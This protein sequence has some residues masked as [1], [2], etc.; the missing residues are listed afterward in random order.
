[1]KRLSLLALLAV[2]VGVTGLVSAPASKLEPAPKPP[3]ITPPTTEALDSAIRHGIAFLLKDQNKDGSWGTAERTKGL[4]IYAPVPGAHHAFRTAVTA[5]VLSALIEIG[6]GDDVHKAIDRGEQWLFDNLPILRRA[7]PDALYNIWGHGYAVG[8]LVRMHGRK[9]ADAE[10]R[11]KIEALIQSQ[12]DYLTR[13]ESV[14]GGWG[15]YDFRVGSKKPATD[16]TSFMTAAL[17]VCFK[18]AKDIGQPPPQKVLQAAIDSIHRQQKPDFTYLYGEYM[19]WRPMHPINLPGGSLGR[20]QACNVA[21]RLWGDDKITDEVLKNWL[22][23]LFARNGWLDMGRK[24]PIPHESHFAVAGYFY[25]F[26]HYYAALCIEQLKPDQRAFFQDYLAKILLGLQEQDGS[27]WDYP[28]YNYH[29]QYGTAFTLMALHHCRHDETR[30][31]RPEQ[32]EGRGWCVLTASSR[33]SKTPGA[34]LE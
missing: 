21:L 13:Y 25:Y 16:S 29:Q 22:E 2:V 26:G 17:L 23:R 14:D 9:P 31:A 34:P 8:A 15:Y 32:R 11:K 19:K 18:E 10:R 5:L 1:M 20:S 7:T 33:P 30:V 3:P 24:R 27:W 28:L 4:N 12:Y 6:G